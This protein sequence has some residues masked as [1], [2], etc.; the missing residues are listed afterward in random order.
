MKKL[1]MVICAMFIGIARADE[2]NIN[3]MNGS[4]LYDTSTCTVGGDLNTPPAPQKYGYNFLGWVSFTPIEYIESTGT[5]YINTGISPNQDTRFMMTFMVTRRASSDNYIFGVSGFSFRATG[6]TSC[7]INWVA[8]KWAN[9][10]CA[11]NK[12]F[13]VDASNVWT[14]YNEDGSVKSKTS[15]DKTAWSYTAPF[16]IGAGDTNFSA[17][18]YIGGLKIYSAKIWDND[19]LVR[20]FIPV[21]DG[22]GVACLY[23][24]VSNEYFYN[25]G[26]G[27]FNPGPELTE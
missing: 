23:D 10:G 19:E 6:D 14:L 12:K 1:L 11:L 18:G 21:L 16:Y 15:W 3:W 5:Q 24:L 9:T 8:S 20:N 4:T 22:N 13:T 26:T 7:S 27:D 2:I 17:S 25:A